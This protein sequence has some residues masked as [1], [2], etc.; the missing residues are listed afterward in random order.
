[1]AGYP[2]R[3]QSSESEEP[4]KARS[5]TVWDI[6]TDAGNFTVWESGITWVDGYVRNGAMIRIRTVDGGNR[7]FRTH[8]QQM[9]GQVMTWKTGIPPG[10]L[11]W[12]CTYSISPHAGLTHLRVKDEFAG[13][14][15]KLASIALPASEQDLHSYVTAIRRPAPNCWTGRHSRTSRAPCFR[16]FRNRR[17]VP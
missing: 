4:I 15:L 16:F 9:P 6:I 14:L 12:T 5:S 7:T 2:W 8:V 1:M 10:L 3:M 11:T 13:P 17:A